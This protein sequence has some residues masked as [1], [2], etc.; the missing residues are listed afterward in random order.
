MP[1]PQR[2]SARSRSAARRDAIDRAV[3]GTIV[4]TSVLVVYDGWPDLKLGDAIVVILG[5]MV[6]IVIGHVFAASVAAYPELGRRPRRSEL[7]HIVRRE[8]RFLLVCVPQLVLLLTLTS[9]RFGLSHT[10]RVL[11][12]TG[13]VS[14]G[15]WAGTAAWRA[16]VRGRGL[17]LAVVT[18]LAVG[19]GRSARR[20]AS[21]GP[22]SAATA[23]RSGAAGAA[24]LAGGDRATGLRRRALAL[25][26]VT[27]GFRSA[28][29]SRP[30]R[31]L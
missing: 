20:D 18:G 24:S 6:A 7:L 23:D 13:P 9:A 4:V 12:W 31:P 17:A 28:P 21:V 19:S 3:Y 1:Q 22:S 14:L 2:Y 25:G 26:L 29:R 16:G 27:R 8:S 5:P 11:I 10:V 30:A 15:F